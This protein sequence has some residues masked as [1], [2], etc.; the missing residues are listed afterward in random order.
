[1]LFLFRPDWLNSEKW[2]QAH[3]GFHKAWGHILM[4]VLHT[5]T[6]PGGDHNNLM[7]FYFQVGC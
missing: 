7:I 1:M 2:L 3:F 6:V 5:F 4:L